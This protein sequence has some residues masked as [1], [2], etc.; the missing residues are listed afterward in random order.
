ML[1]IILGIVILIAILVP[2]LLPM[3]KKY[4]HKRCKFCKGAMKVEDVKCKNCKR[5]QS[6]Q[7]VEE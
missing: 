6:E 2:I 1:F 4:T 5:L 7:S 3:D